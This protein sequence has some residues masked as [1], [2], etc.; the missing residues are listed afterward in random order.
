MSKPHQT[1]SNNKSYIISSDGGFARMPSAC[2]WLP[3]YL[4]QLTYST[5][6]TCLMRNKKSILDFRSFHNGTP[7]CISLHHSVQ[8]YTTISSAPLHHGILWTMHQTATM[9]IVYS[10]RQPRFLTFFTTYHVGPTVVLTKPV[11]V[12]PESLFGCGGT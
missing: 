9:L 7:K 6:A 11:N 5:V 4:Q 10:T 1:S 2:A 3:R 8:E 12:Q